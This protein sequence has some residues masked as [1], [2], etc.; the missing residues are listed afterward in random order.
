MV[1]FGQVSE[2]GEFYPVGDIDKRT[3]AGAPMVSP[4]FVAT[5]GIH[6]VARRSFARS[7]DQ[8]SSHDV[9]VSEPLARALYGKSDVVGEALSG[10]P[11]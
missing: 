1:P 7:D 6:L 8:P 9:I 2:G 11:S 10:G 4:V 3:W 5:M